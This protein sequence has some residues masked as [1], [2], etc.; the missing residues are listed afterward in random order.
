MKEEHRRIQFVSDQL[1]Q[2]IVEGKKTA[3]V[4]KIEVLEQADGA[5]DDPIV[6]GKYY[7][8][9]DSRL[10][11]RATIRIMMMEVCRWDDIPERLWRGETNS[12]A[13]EFRRDHLDYFDHPGRDFE[14]IAYY[15]KLIRY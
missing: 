13:E 15:F 14:F 11:V 2:Q 7:D 6:V 10:A 4:V 1:V 5:Y 9:F 12:S 8:V 3:S